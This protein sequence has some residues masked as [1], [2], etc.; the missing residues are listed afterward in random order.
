MVRV[1]HCRSGRCTGGKGRYLEKGEAD[2]A[3]EGD[4]R[5][6][7]E[8]PARA[9][10]SGSG[11]GREARTHDQPHTRPSRIVRL[12]KS[13]RLCR[14]SHQDRKD[15]GTT[16]PEVKGRVAKGLRP[17]A[18]GAPIKGNLPDGVSS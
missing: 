10:G 17:A 12:D 8:R 6:R 11:D 9:S 3:N 16:T 15:N 13:K 18:G 2:M 4:G 7:W 14:D 1:G 5:G